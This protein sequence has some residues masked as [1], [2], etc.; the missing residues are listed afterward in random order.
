MF[1][2]LIYTTTFIGLILAI[3]LWFTGDKDAGLFVGI[4]VPLILALGTFAK[5]TKNSG[6]EIYLFNRLSNIFI[7]SLCFV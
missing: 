6:R 3:Y 1:S 4:W 7:G 5:V 2:R